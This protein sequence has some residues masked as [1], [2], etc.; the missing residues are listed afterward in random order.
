MKST[1]HFSSNITEEVNKLVVTKITQCMKQ[2]RSIAETIVATETLEGAGVRLHRGFGFHELSRFDPFLL[3]DDFSS[4]VE[5][6]YEAG[7]PLHPHRGIETITYLLR[8][9]VRHK[10]SIGNSGTIA[11]GDVQW[12]TAGSGIVHEEMPEGDTGLTGFQLWVNLSKIHKMMTPRYQEISA[13]T[14]PV[15]QENGVTTRVI[16][17]E[18]RGIRGPVEDIM[19]HPQYLDVTLKEATP[20]QIEIP[21]NDTAFIYI[22][23]GSLQIGEKVCE[24]GSI[25]RFE[26]DA[27]EIVL[28]S[29]SLQSRFLCISATPL[30]E[31]IAWYGP[32]VMNTDEELKTALAELRDGTFIQ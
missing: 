6:D 27:S 14:I 20:W 2:F 21:H 19:A 9:D 25:V 24:R 15:V 18:Y 17:G 12:M 3:F 23:E 5:S 30:G 4:D 7:F 1:L 29:L 26:N 11:S 22:F 13:S 8:G 31:P 10:D 28:T 32:I 16:S